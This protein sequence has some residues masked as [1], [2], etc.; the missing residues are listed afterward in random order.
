M[1]II[2]FWIKLRGNWCDI[3]PIGLGWPLLRAAFMCLAYTLSYG[4]YP[5]ASLSDVAACFF[6][7]PIFV[8]VFAAIFLKE[9]IGIWRIS[10]VFLGFTGAL[11]IIQPG[12]VD[13][14]PVL[15]M[16]VLAG[17]CYAAGVVITRGFC[18]SQPSL[19]LTAVHNLFYAVLG[20]LVVSLLSIF[21]INTEVI[22][23]NPFLFSKWAA[24]TL[25][26]VYMIVAT[27][28]THIIAM[29]ASIR[30]YQVA[31]STFVAPIEYSYLVFVAI[32]DFAIWATLPSVTTLIGVALVVGSGLL[33]SFREL[34]GEHRDLD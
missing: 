25:P 6:T 22:L 26:V 10:A 31:E 2:C 30:A 24:L 13:F 27:A 17:A 7:A 23:Q 32:I 4:A 21:P 12:T 15:M 29:T 11:F 8:C 1:L 18:S 33:I 16:P 28:A 9:R 20:I 14:R 34:I 3:I 5:F 19:A